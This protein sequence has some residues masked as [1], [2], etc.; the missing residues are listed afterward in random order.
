MRRKVGEYLSFLAGEGYA[1]S[2]LAARRKTL[3]LFDRCGFRVPGFLR[4][5]SS[6]P[7]LRRMQIS[8]LRLFLRFARRK[9]AASI[10]LPR[11]PRPPPLWAPGVEEVKRFLV[12]LEGSDPIS[13]RDRAMAELIYSAALRACEAA[14]LRLPD[15]DFA[16]RLLRVQGKGRRQRMAPFG[17][18][19]AEWIVRYL[20]QARPKLRPDGE[21]L[22]VGRGG[23]PLGVAAIRSRL[24]PLT[25]HR[26][27]RAAA[28]HCLAGGMNLREV[29]ELLGHADLKN[30]ARYTGVREAELRKVLQ[31]H[32][33]RG[34]MCVRE[35]SCHTQLA[36]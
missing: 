19:A 17:R 8:H 27:R 2:T 28:T 6:G 13:I 11:A 20:S 36:R 12:S 35:N 7:H 14:R 1:A 29:Q 31:E 16:G 22:F 15:V 21:A 24:R 10:R 34:A 18:A 9:E 4:R 32:H 30:T 33:P 23:R 25:P 3:A 5:L 26:L